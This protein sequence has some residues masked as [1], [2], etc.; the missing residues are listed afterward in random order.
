MNE[1]FI[2]VHPPLARYAMW[3]VFAVHGVVGLIYFRGSNL[4][5]PK[6]VTRSSKLFWHPIRFLDPAE[7]TTA[8]L[9]WR[10]RYFLWFLS[11]SIAMVVLFSLYA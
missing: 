10:R 7:W 2:P 6:L 9:R 1:I 3:L 8:G 5:D 11:S 4:R